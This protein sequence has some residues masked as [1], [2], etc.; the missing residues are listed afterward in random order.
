MGSLRLTVN[1]G[2]GPSSGGPLPVRRAVLRFPA[3]L[4]IEIPH[5]RSASSPACA[6]AAPAAAPPSQSSAQATP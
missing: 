5:L 3:G 6:P 2:E 1:F 4:G